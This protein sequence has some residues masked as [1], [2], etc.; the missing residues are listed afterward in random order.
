MAFEAKFPRDA[1][2]ELYERMTEDGSWKL[3]REQERNAPDL[4]AQNSGNFNLVRSLPTEH[5]VRDMLDVAYL[6][7]LLEEEGRRVNFTLGFLSPSGAAALKYIPMPFD[8]PRPFRPNTLAKVALATMP[9]RTTFGVWPS[10][11][12]ELEIWGFVQH[13]DNTFAIDINPA[14]TYFSLDVLRAGTFTVHFDEHLAM[15]FSRDHYHVFRNCPP[16]GFDIT[17]LLRERAHLPGA[18]A[19]T[20]RRLARRVFAHGHGG[21]ILFVDK[22]VPVRRLKT[23]PESTF[24]GEAHGILK[25]TL[26]DLESFTRDTTTA[27]DLDLAEKVR[28]RLQLERKHAEALDFVGRLTAVDGAVVLQNDLG[29]LGFGATIVTSEDAMPEEVAHLDPRRGDEELPLR[30]S[31]LGGNRH[32]SAVCFCASQESLALALVCS[33]DGDLSIVGRRNK[34]DVLVVRPYEFALGF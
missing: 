5:Q 28:R 15:L 29:L 3:L 26:N 25:D 20:L 19:H 4:A 34:G 33:Q 11:A 9:G 16:A 1:A 21:A 7:S 2:P 30:L 22:D 10:S 6:A 12:G 27:G 23:Y 32:R 24:K 13:G 31:D 14:P 18:V 8:K 17:G